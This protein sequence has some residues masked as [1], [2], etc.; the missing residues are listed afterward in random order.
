MDQCRRFGSVIQGDVA[1]IRQDGALLCRS[2][3][4][5]KSTCVVCAFGPLAKTL[6]CAATIAPHSAFQAENALIECAH[7]LGFSPKV[8]YGGFHWFPRNNKP[9]TWSGPE[10]SSHSG[11]LMCRGVAGGSHHPIFSILSFSNRLLWLAKNV[12]RYS[13][14]SGVF[15]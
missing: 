7:F 15:N 11:G 8:L 4:T 2:E 14:C 1:G 10:G 6:A 13:V 5:S 3:L 12:V 9:Q